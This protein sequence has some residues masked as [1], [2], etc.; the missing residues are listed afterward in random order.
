MER[1]KTSLLMKIEGYSLALKGLEQNYSQLANRLVVEQ[2]HHKQAMINV[3]S[4]EAM[5]RSL[6]HELSQQ[7]LVRDRLLQ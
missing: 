2:T 7:G 1:E 5:L 4:K 6:E 3:T